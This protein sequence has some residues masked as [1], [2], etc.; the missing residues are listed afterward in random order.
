MAGGVAASLGG[1]RVVASSGLAGGCFA[2]DAFSG[3]GARLAAGGVLRLG[4]LKD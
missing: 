4:S 1:G 3:L 2:E